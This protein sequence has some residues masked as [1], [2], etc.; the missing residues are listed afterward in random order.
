[1]ASAEA[2]SLVGADNLHAAAA[3]A[4]SGLEDDRKANLARQSFGFFVGANAA[5]RPRH[6]RDAKFNGG[7]FGGDLVAHQADV[8][9][10]RT[11]KLHVVVGENFGKAR[12]LGEKAVARM[13]SIGAGDLAGR[14]QSRN[15]EIAVLGG[16]RADA[17]ALVGEPHM[18]G[19]SIRRRMHRHRRNA[20]LFARAAGRAVRFPPGWRSGS[21]RTS[22]PW[23]RIANGKERAGGGP[24][25]EFAIRYFAIRFTL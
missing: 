24:S 14:E 20:E 23:K 17:D 4:G 19:V 25:L 12:I 6:G 3:A 2:I 22:R 5:V 16:R 15:V 10:P 13:N 7:A 21:C 1:M 8:L 18:H 9:G 11:D